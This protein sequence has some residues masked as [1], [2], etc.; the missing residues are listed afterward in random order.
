MIQ[1][2]IFIIHLPP[3]VIG[4]GKMYLD[5]DTLGVNLN[6]VNHVISI[7]YSAI[8]PLRTPKIIVPSSSATLIPIFI[9]DVHTA[10][11]IVQYFQPEVSAST[12]HEVKDKR[13][14]GSSL[15]AVIVVFG[16][17]SAI[18]ITVFVE[19]MFM[20]SLAWI[21]CGCKI[22]GIKDI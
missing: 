11:L 21:I 7:A 17:I 10:S 8:A 14:M 18:S 3:A 15:N 1:L 20:M 22:L 4:M 6:V 5:L 12:I 13:T 16:L 2:N 19:L 9:F